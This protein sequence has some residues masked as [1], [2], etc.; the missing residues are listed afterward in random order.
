MKN[1]SEVKVTITTRGDDIEILDR[2][3]EMIP[4]ED[5]SALSYISYIQFCML[6]K[7]AENGDVFPKEYF[8][9]GHPLGLTE[10]EF[11]V[12]IENEFKKLKK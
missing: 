11:D 6:E 4:V 8:P 2:I 10:E 12:F 5:E 3:S 7:L 9:I 1:S